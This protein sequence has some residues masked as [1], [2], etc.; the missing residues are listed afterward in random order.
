MPGKHEIIFTERH[1]VSSMCVVGLNSYQGRQAYMEDRY[2]VITNINGSEISLYSIFDG[3]AGSFAADYASEIIMPG[4]S[5]KITEILEL[6]KA[7]GQKIVSEI[8]PRDENENSN[9][10]E[11]EEE[12]PEPEPNPLEQYITPENTINY[13]KLLHDQIL[14][15]DKILIERM[16]KANLFGGSTANIVLVDLTNKLIICANVGDSR[17]VMCDA[18]GK[19]FALSQDHKPNNA[20]EVIRIRENGGYISNK[21]GC[22]RV[23]GTLACSRSL[24]DY[25]LKQKKVIIPDPDITTFKF[26]DF[27]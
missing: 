14:A 7:K 2:S 19:A 4:I 11:E 1:Q 23:D 22:W 18:K 6:I 20:E 25:P 21:S 17:A 8:K 27:K 10:S 9:K 5:E 13:E 3:H 26:K 24:G 15:F 12:L 16:S